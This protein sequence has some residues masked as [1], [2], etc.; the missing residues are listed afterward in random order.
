MGIL[1]ALH[2]QTELFWIDADLEQHRPETVG[3]DAKP[4]VGDFWGDHVRWNVRD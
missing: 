4:D 1:D 3:V 2:R